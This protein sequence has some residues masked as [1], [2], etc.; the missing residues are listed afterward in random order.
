MTVVC[1]FYYIMQEPIARAGNQW[2]L[3]TWLYLNW[4]K[5]GYKHI[6]KVSIIICYYKHSGELTIRSSDQ[7]CKLTITNTTIN[8]QN[9]EFDY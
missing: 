8:D 5:K 2:S 9:G 1:N 6:P 3:N 4:E 7:N